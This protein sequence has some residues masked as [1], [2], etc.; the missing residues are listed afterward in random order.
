MFGR[1]D[2]HKGQ[3]ISSFGVVSFLRRLLKMKKCGHSGTLDPMATG[4]LSV[5]VGKATTFIDRMR[6]P[7]KEY[8]GTLRFGYNSDTFDIWGRLEPAPGVIP[9]R[10]QIEAVLPRFIGEISQ[11]PPMVSALK[12]QGKPLYKYARQGIIVDRPPR[13]VFIEKIICHG[14]DGEEAVFTVRCSKGTYIR[15]L[16]HDIAHE[17]GTSGVMSKL[18]RVE[19][20]GISL[21]ACFTLDEIE[22]MVRAEDYRF[23]RNVGDLQPFERI[24]IGPFLLRNWRR[25]IKTPMSAEQVSD[26]RVVLTYKGSFV[27][28][29]VRSGDSFLPEKV[30]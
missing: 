30:I 12:H 3:N 11:V 28:T 26:E 25:G 20:D 6:T 8:V 23:L 24:E 29:A 19:N 16:F 17:L 1:V 4:V 14:I 21:D 15:T 9:S 13:S 18:V 2:V 22:S 27:G 7:M 10:H 5:Y